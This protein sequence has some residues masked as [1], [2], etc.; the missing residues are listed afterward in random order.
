MQ[1]YTL[2]EVQDMLNV[3]DKTIMRA[4]DKGDMEAM[5]IGKLWRI[6]DEQLNAYLAKRTVSKT[7]R[8]KLTL[9]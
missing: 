6:S 3:S 8:K 2:K 9:I 7:K 5:K 1:I 4:I